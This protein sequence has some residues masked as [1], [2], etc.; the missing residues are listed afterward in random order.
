MPETVSPAQ[1]EPTRA[2]RKRGV[3]RAVKR[4]CLYLLIFYVMWLAALTLF[5][6]KMIFPRDLA[7]SPLRDALIPRDAQRV[8]IDANDGARVEAWYFPAGDAKRAV[9]AVIFFHGNAELI[10]FNLSLVK[11][12]HDRG[13][14]VLLP[15]FRGY[16]RSNGSPS[17]K[18]LVADAVTF[19]DWLV[20]QPGVDTSR[21]IFH[22]RSIG[23][24]VAAQLA[25]VQ[26][27][28]AL[29]LES[30][31]TS[32]AALAGRFGAPGFLVRHPFHTDRVLPALDC[33]VL[34]LH[35]HSD[36]IVPFDHAVKLHALAPGSVFVKM[37][38]S[39]NS[40][41]S[42]QEGYWNAVDG[43]LSGL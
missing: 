1:P 17:Q 42:E 22:G 4:G 30:P 38:G 24:G 31:F 36:E 8:W 7:G 9:P 19:H 21:L 37:D 23:T 5:Q 10:D 3:R 14:S 26:K 18:A 32:I 35:G 33:K 39:H 41:L 6:E 43:L 29:I 16:G 12:Y 40:G 20:K 34:I 2:R 28:A 25:S 27:P 15:E 13:V 11:R